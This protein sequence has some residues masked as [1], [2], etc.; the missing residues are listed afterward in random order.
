MRVSYRFT[1]KRRLTFANIVGLTHAVCVVT[2]RLGNYLYISHRLVSDVLN[3]PESPG[4]KSAWGREVTIQP[5]SAENPIG[6][7]AT[8]KSEGPPQESVPAKAA[9]ATKILAARTGTLRNPDKSYLRMRLDAYI[10]TFMVPN[11]FVYTSPEQLRPERGHTGVMMLGASQVISGR[12]VFVALIG[13]EHNFDY[14]NPREP[15]RAT[16]GRT[17]SD[18]DGLYELFQHIREPQDPEVQDYRLERSRKMSDA[19]IAHDAMNLLMGSPGRVL[20]RVEVLAKRHRLPL[21]NVVLSSYQGPFDLVILGA[22]LW[23]REVD[24]EEGI[25]APPRLD[26]IGGDEVADFQRARAKVNELVLRRRNVSLAIRRAGGRPP[27]LMQLPAPDRPLSAEAKEYVTLAVEE[28][29]ASRD[30]LATALTDE[31]WPRFAAWFTQQAYTAGLAYVNL[32][33][34]RKPPWWKRPFDRHWSMRLP[35]PSGINGYVIPLP[36]PE[37]GGRTGWGHDYVLI[38][39]DGGIYEVMVQSFHHYEETRVVY[40]PDDVEYE[41]GLPPHRSPTPRPDLREQ[42]AEAMWDLAFTWRDTLDRSDTPDSPWAS[43]YM[44]EQD[45]P[46]IGVTDIFRVPGVPS[47]VALDW[48]PDEIDAEPVPEPDDEPAPD[49][50]WEDRHED[51]AS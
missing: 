11:G 43:R 27:D 23:I 2:E 32:A 10:G 6:V 22:P 40:W 30:A 24:T 45:L 16:H 4:R 20:R 12:R 29:S 13:S 37:P 18:I 42:A 46:D 5:P 33:V 39:R 28:M 26:V 1:P 17:P 35:E 36:P 49:A 47:P 48:T 14:D 19:D 15:I 8:F 9:R 25:L 50:E 51:S 31:G 38:T 7:S 44:L 21:R 41:D 3:Q 34:E